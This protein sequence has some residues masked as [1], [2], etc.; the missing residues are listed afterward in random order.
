MLD[1]SSWV[2]LLLSKGGSGIWADSLHEPPE[3]SVE[4]GCHG[5]CTEAL[6]GKDGATVGMTSTW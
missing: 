5:L 6:L 1:D 4:E 3:N 2:L